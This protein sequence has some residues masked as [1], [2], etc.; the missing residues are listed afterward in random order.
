MDS[1][2]E[3][4]LSRVEVSKDSLNAVKPVKPSFKSL[5]AGKIIN[6]PYPVFY[7][8]SIQARALA[9]DSTGALYYFEN[10]GFNRYNENYLPTMYST[11]TPA[12]VTNAKMSWKKQD[13]H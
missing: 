1:K 11:V 10:F 2:I 9:T 12:E 4:T 5:P 6:P 8:H 7:V 13:I 3:N